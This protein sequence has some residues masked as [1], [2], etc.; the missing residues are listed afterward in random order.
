MRNP[1]KRFLLPC[2]ILMEVFVFSSAGTG[3]ARPGDRTDGVRLRAGREVFVTEA[4]EVNAMARFVDRMVSS[5]NLKLLSVQAENVNA[6]RH[7]RFDQYYRDI[8]VWGGQLIRHTRAGEVYAVSGNYFEGVSLD[9]VPQIDRDQATLA[10]HRAL[11][12][13]DC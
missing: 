8:K 5:G 2:L 11:P 7:E 3:G 4:R 6:Y 10:A 13:A 1:K 12:G 9:P